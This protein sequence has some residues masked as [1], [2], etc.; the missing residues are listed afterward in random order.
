MKTVTLRNLPRELAHEVSRRS[1][2]KRLSLNRTV[3]ELLA[4]RLGTAKSSKEAKTGAKDPGLL[5]LAGSWSADEA[6][7]FDETLALQR[8]ID[9][10]LW[11]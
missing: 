5:G 7:A 1:R 11:K 4:E 3:V 8:R 9:P 6:R 2:E 10:D